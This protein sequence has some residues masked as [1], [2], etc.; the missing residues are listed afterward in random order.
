MYGGKGLSF[1]RSW[2]KLLATLL[3]QVVYSE[4][5]SHV[6]AHAIGDKG[7]AIQSLI[8]GKEHHNIESPEKNQMD[9]MQSIIYYT[10]SSQA[11]EGA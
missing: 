9:H 11:P 5:G 3:R 2:G 7:P 6:R 10:C 8:M 4:S 1:Q